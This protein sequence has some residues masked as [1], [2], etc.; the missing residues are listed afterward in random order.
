MKKKVDKIG[1]FSENISFFDQE[2]STMF[3]KGELQLHHFGASSSPSLPRLMG[4]VGLV[5]TF[6]N[7]V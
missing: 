4:F 7:T 1:D 5:A 2:V 6:K 3:S